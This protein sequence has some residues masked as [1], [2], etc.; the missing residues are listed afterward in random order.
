MSPSVKKEKVI[1]KNQVTDSCPAAFQSK[2][3]GQE[4]LS[5]VI[6]VI[7]KS[8]SPESSLWCGHIRGRYP[9]KFQRTHMWFPVKIVWK[10]FQKFSW[11]WYF[12]CTLPVE[13]CFVIYSVKASGEIPFSNWILQSYEATPWRL[14]SRILERKAFLEL[15]QSLKDAV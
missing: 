13:W 10:Y 8:W 6:S 12:L 7:L 14:V 9:E 4:I 5:M 15:H 2:L 11:L 1:K 3:I